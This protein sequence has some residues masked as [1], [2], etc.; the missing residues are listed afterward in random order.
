M[1]GAKRKVRAAGETADAERR[2]ATAADLE[3]LLFVVDRPLARREVEDR[4]GGGASSGGLQGV[5]GERG[6]QAL[7]HDL[8]GAGREVD[9]GGTGHNGPVGINRH[10]RDGGPGRN[11]GGEG[12]QGREASKA[13]Q[14]EAFHED[15]GT[16]CPARAG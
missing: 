13:G 8:V 4:G 6:R 2:P 7:E 15:K 12:G 16:G 9:R 3:A 14:G 1:T 10:R 5:V 11:R